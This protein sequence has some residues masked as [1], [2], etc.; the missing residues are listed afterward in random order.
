MTEQS[1][2]IMK[3][4]PYW[5]HIGLKEVE[6]KDGYSILELPIIHEVTQSRNNV[7]GGVIASMVDAA[8]GAALRSM[9][10]VG[11]AG[12]T[13]EMKLNYLRP[14]NGEKLIAKGE[15]IKKGGSLAIGQAVIENDAGDEVAVGL[16]TYMIKSK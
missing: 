5:D 9:L 8:V 14:A 1:K 13:V 7:H 12:V 15:I 11:K 10:E 6:L 3:H 16:V 2:N 4:N